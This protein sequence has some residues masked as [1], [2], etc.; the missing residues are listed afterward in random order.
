MGRGE[1]MLTKE[2]QTRIVGE[3]ADVL[4]S[5]DTYTDQDLANR[6]SLSGRD[7][8]LIWEAREIVRHTDGI[9][10]GAIPRWP[11][12]FRRLDWSQVERQA[13]RQRGAGTRKHRRAEEKLR[14]A[15]T[16]APEQ[17]KERLNDAADRV[18]LRLAMRSART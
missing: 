5:V 15:S 8:K 13:N 4:R 18:A 12:N 6:W 7:R 2:E 11:G 3:I 17:S 16:L 1:T 14:L 10:F 9:V